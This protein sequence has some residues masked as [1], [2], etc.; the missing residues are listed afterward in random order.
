MSQD[1][2]A[3]ARRL[4]RAASRMDKARR[5]RDLLIAEATDAGMS[6]RELGLAVGLTPAGVQHVLKRLRETP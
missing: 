3:L 6:R 4:S 1:K 2:R 5:D